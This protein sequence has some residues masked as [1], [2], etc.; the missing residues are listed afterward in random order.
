MAGVI[1]EEQEFSPYFLRSH[2]FMRAYGQ[3]QIHILGWIEA[4]LSSPHIRRGQL[5]FSREEQELLK[6]FCVGWPQLQLSI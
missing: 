4:R 5:Q 6:L 3:V 1:L 2:E